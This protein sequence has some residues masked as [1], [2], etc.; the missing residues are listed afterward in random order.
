MC[1]QCFNEVWLCWISRST[2][3]HS[4]EVTSMLQQPLCQ[5]YQLHCPSSVYW[6]MSA[7]SKPN[8]NSGCDVPYR[9]LF[10]YQRLAHGPAYTRNTDDGLLEPHCSMFLRGWL[11]FFIHH[12]STRCIICT[13]VLVTNWTFSQ[14][15]VHR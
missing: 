12:L 13:Y 3:I 11:V 9:R 5:D 8:N 6:L 2:K 1:S 14:A 4:M 10:F 15:L 7:S